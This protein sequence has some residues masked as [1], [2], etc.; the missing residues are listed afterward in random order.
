M[1]RLNPIERECQDALMSIRD[2][3]TVTPHRASIRSFMEVMGKVRLAL[4]H[5]ENKEFGC[6][7]GKHSGPCICRDGAA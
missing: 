4:L 1:D 2:I 6:A 5:L 7:T 3:W